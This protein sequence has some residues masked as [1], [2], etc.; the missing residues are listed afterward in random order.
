MKNFLIIALVLCSPITYVFSQCG[1]CNANGNKDWE[2][3]VSSDWN[4][5]NNW[6]GNTFP[7]V[8]SDIVIDAT[9]YTNAPIISTASSFTPRDV[10]IE[11]AGVLTIQA[12]FTFSDDLTMRDNGST[13]FIEGG[14][15]ATGDD[16]N[17]CNGG[18]INISGGDFSN[19]S[20]SGILRVCTT[21]PAG[22]NTPEINITGGTFTSTTTET[23]GGTIVDD[24]VTVTGSTGS[25]SDGDGVT[26]PVELL[27]FNAESNLDGVQL[28]WS[29]AS[30]LNNSHFS[31]E[32]SID[33]V[34]FNVIAQISGNGTTSNQ[35]YY[36]FK[37]YKPGSVN[38]YRLI[39]YDY[40]GSEEMLSTIRLNSEFQKLSHVSYSY[41]M[42]APIEISSKTPFEVI[43]YEKSGKV[44]FTEAADN[45]ISI[46]MTSF[47]PGIYILKILS[48][49][50]VQTEKILL[51]K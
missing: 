21:T 35:Q 48:S 43:V 3:D 5:A 20:G 24:F 19:E 41:D 47:L 16:I 9:K 12:S 39:Q 11:N 37:D 45:S 14:S 28:E 18:V 33:Q 2:G 17:L 8:N 26:L 40:D 44:I 30:E 13:L 38:Y 42:T 6:E 46:P 31:I 7:G 49:D 51:K 25:Y 50:A 10:V 36:S 22:Q 32:R 4:D 27:Y 15:N 1:S 34:N 23:P 29:T